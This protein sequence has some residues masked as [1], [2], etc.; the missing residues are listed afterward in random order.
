MAKDKHK[1]R[2]VRFILASAFGG[3]FGYATAAFLKGN[4]NTGLASLTIGLLFAVL[5]IVAWIVDCM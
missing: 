5:F 1:M 3:T 2:I 4:L